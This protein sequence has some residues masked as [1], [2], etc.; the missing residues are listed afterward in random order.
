[1]KDRMQLESEVLTWFKNAD[2]KTKERVFE[3]LVFMLSFEELT[4]LHNAELIPTQVR[5]T[6][7][8]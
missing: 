7:V 6:E 4:T 1:M 5:D 2:V 3:N 8:H